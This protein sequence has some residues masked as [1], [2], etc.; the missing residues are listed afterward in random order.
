MKKLLPLLLL[1]AA[2]ASCTR[3][4]VISGRIEG[5]TNDTLIVVSCKI[6]D[7]PDLSDDLD[8]RIR[9][10]TI[11]ARQG[12][13]TFDIPVEVPTQFIISPAQLL[14]TVHGRR[15]FTRTSDI[16]LF[17]DKGEHVVLKGRIDSS[18]FNCTIEGT[19]LNRELSR[20]KQQDLPLS[21]EM[22]R[23]QNSMEGKPRAEQERIFREFEQIAER[24]RLRRTEYAMANPNSPVAAYYLTYAPFD[25]LEHYYAKLGEKAR[26]SIFKPLIDHLRLRADKYC[27]VQAAKAGTA[28]GMP[29]PEFVLRDADGKEFA[30]SSLRGRYVVLDFWGSWCGWCIKGFP[31]MKACYERYKD[32]LEIVGI[33]CNDT[34]EKWREAIGRHGLPWVHVINPRN[35]A[36]GDDVTVRYAVEGYPTKIVIDPEGR[37]AARFVGESEEFYDKLAE[38]LE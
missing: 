30:L 23:L 18:V 7:M 5:L 10:D 6:A 8:S 24:Q 1:A 27:K 13:L 4:P 32:K 17:L 31:R 36:P 2:T 35:A 22:D 29:A 21:V 19:R 11:L 26:N 9:Y 15:Y 16:R 33:A 34:P 37:I 38:M 12:R 14:E 25:S 3:R 20:N 28:P